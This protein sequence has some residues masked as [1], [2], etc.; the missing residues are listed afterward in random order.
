MKEKANDAKKAQPTELC[1]QKEFTLDKFPI[2]LYM[3]ERKPKYKHTHTSIK[4]ISY[5]LSCNVLKKKKALV[6]Y[7]CT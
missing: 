1:S 2:Y 5:K 7:C 3:H 6:E 4:M